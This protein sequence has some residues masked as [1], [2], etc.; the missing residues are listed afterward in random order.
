MSLSLLAR[1]GDWVAVDKPPGLAVVPGRDGAEDCVRARLEAQ[2]GARVW[3]CHRIDRDTS[4]VLLFATSAQAHRAASMAFEAGQVRKRYVALVEGRVE[5]PLDIAVPLTPARRGRMRPA[6]DGEAG[7][8]ARSLVRPRQAWARASLV[9]VEP[10]TGRQH[11]IR[12]HLK[13][14]GHP[15]LVDHQYGAR[16]PLTAAQLG[17]QGDEVLLARTPLHAEALE[18]EAL[19]LRLFAPLPDDMARCV[20]ALSG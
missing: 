17:G 8:A 14:A 19:G 18:C 20:A 5:T 13:W 4:G 3:V 9:E 11:Q 2:L 16:G 1:V 15:L 10:L 7:K 6:A 12:V